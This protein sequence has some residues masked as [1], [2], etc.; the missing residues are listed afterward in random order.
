M[1]TLLLT[2]F[3]IALVGAVSVPAASARHTVAHRVTALETKVRSLQRTV[4]NLRAE[5][6]CVT[7]AFAVN[8]YGDGA[9]G[10]FGY[11][12]DND[13]GGPLPPLYA[14]GLAFA[15]PGETVDAWLAT[16][17]PA[18]LSSRR[19]PAANYWSTATARKKPTG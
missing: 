8:Q 14:T 9:T 10:T 19:A 18:C 17:D 16:M 13:G 4:R 2:A 1:R 3:V 5:V 6:A 7:G 15:G 11:V 12:F